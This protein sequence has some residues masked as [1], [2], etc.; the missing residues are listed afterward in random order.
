M[1]CSPIREPHLWDCEDWTT[2]HW[3]R[4]AVLE[5]GDGRLGIAVGIAGEVDR[6]KE[7]GKDSGWSSHDHWL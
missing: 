5:P 6:L 4:L 7:R 1:V 2:L 3:S